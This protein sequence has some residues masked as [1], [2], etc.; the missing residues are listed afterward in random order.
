LD[1]VK[2]ETDGE[3]ANPSNPCHMENSYFTYVHSTKHKALVCHLSI[4]LSCLAYT[5]SDS[6]GQ[7]SM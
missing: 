3:M 7:H 6:P 1:Q 4:H 5:K 2:E